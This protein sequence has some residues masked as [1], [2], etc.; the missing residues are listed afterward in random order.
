MQRP[1]DPSDRSHMEP[2]PFNSVPAPVVILFLA[3]FA[4][5]C[6]F[7]G[8]EAGLIG[9]PGGIGWRLAA[10]GDYGFAPPIWSWM[11]QTGQFPG[12]EMLRLVTYPFLHL[13]FVHMAIAGVIFLAMGK[14]VGEVMGAWV[15]PVLF[16]ACS[17]LAAVVYGTLLNEETWLVG[18]YPGAYGLIGAF[19]FVLWTRARATGQAQVQAFSLIGFLMG[20]QLVFGL[21]F[22]TDNTWVADLAGFVVGFALSFLLVPGGFAFLLRRLRGD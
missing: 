4:V 15:V 2:S 5:E 14:F 22:G 9:G 20:I 6:L 7:A 19:T 10:I 1:E 3:M 11:L 21:L 18:A 12:S 17:V 13:G 8:A 16:F